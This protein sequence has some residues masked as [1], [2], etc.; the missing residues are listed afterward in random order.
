MRELTA[1]RP[2]HLLQVGKR[3]LLEHLILAIARG[4]VTEFVIITGYFGNQIEEHL[5]DGARFGLRFHYLRQERQDGTGSAARLARS[6]VGDHPFLLTFGDIL[7]SPENYPRLIE[8]FE[9][10]PCD[11]LL[12]LV[13]MEDPYRGAAVYVDA[14]LRVTRIVEKPPAGTSTTPWNNAGLFIFSPLIFEY[15]ERLTP[16][17]RG[18]YELTQAIADMIA[19][20]RRVR[21]LPL[22][23]FWGDVGTPEDLARFRALLAEG[24]D[25]S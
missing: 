14:E 10:E 7:V 21:A 25:G 6:E 1:D 17:S 13:E 2:K 11:G 9:K 23:G 20:G 5:G 16:S 24:E 15:L 12:S 4:G 18:E 3:S 22:R 8:S 19:D